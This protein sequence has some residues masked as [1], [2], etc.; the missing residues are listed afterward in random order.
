MAALVY[1][2][3]CEA[4]FGPHV[5]PVRKYRDIVK[6]LTQD[7]ISAEDELLSPEPASDADLLLVHTAE[8]L[9]KL[10]TN[11]LTPAERY[12]LEIPFSL[13]LFEAMRTAVGGTVLAGRRALEERLAIHIG[14]GFHHAF[15]GHGEGFCLL[16]DVA[17]ATRSL[18]VCGAASRV[19][20]VDCDLHQGNGTAAI[21]RADPRVFTFSVHQE[22]NYPFDKPPS[23]LDIGLEDGAGDGEY[24]AALSVIGDLMDRFHPDIIFYLAGADP[25]EH[26]QLGGLALT[27]EGLLR[28]DRLVIQEARKRDIPLAT[29]LAGGYAVSVEDTVR[30]HVG[31]ISEALRVY[32]GSGTSDGR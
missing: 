3:F 31:T 19:M 28:R 9:H 15:P 7:E 2:R 20:I 11:T 16:N 27:L 25:Y 5:F 21:F 29:V 6:R 23:T 4:A 22:H 10:R 32:N 1:T 24:I 17:V 26:D 8:Y 12:R 18:L 13:E 30:I 14:G